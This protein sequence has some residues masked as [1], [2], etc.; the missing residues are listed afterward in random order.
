M[1]GDDD[2]GT[3]DLGR[4]FRIGRGHDTF[5]TEL[6]VPLRYHVSHIVPV[7][8]RVEHL[9][10]ITT[11]RQRATAHVDVLVQLRQSEP[12]VSDVVDCPHGLY[13]ELQHPGEVQLELY[14]KAGAQI[15]FAVP[16]SDAVYAQHH[17]F[18]AGILGTLQHGPVEAS[19]LVKIKLIDLGCI[20]GLAQLLKAYCTE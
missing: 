2:A 9:R 16:A 1:V 11:D 4:A 15:A 20:V 8:R 10:E 7:H 3:A 13:C 6:T 14:G 17:D 18:D 12:L 5:E 19:I